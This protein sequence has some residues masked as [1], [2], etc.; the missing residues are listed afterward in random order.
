MDNSTGGI[1]RSPWG[2][3]LRHQ[4]VKAVEYEAVEA[5]EGSGPWAAKECSGEKRLG[6]VVG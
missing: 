1:L 5:V 3:E 4:S 6:P 2:D